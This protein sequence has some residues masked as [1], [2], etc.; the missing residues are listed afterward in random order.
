MEVPGTFPAPVGT[1]AEFYGEVVGG[2]HE[3]ALA[4]DRAYGGVVRS[5][6]GQLLEVMSEHVVGLAW[7]KAGGASERLSFQK[8]A[9]KV[10]IRDDYVRRLPAFVQTE[11]SANRSGYFYKGQVDKHVSVDGELVMGVECKAYAEN[12]MLKRVLVDFHLLKS[13]HPSLICCLLQ[14]ESQLGGD[15]SDLAGSPAMGSRPTHTLMSHFPDVELNIVTLLAGERHPE[16]PIHKPEHFKALSPQSLES[17]VGRFAGL[18]A[19]C[20]R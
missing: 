11:I 1:L 5:A 14:L 17:A 3:Q 13:L 12:A 4:S 15:F 7:A 19:P 6:K 20:V 9:Y 8:S 16:R 18:L 2:L 10:P